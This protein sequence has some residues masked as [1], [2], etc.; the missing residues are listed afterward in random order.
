[1]DKGN[2]INRSSAENTILAEALIHYRDEVTPSKKGKSKELG[3][4]D[5]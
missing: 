4:I 5:M 3:R 1:M 2:F